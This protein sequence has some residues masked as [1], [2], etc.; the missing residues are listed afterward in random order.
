M[1]S[2]NRREFLKTTGVA[3]TLAGRDGRSVAIVSDPNDPIASS[4]PATWA[5]GELQRSLEKKGVLVRRRDSIQPGAVDE[6]LIVLSGPSV[7][8]DIPL[9]VVPEAFVLAPA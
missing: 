2:F 6:L 7:R 5:A 4:E 8:A 9:P 3:T 1:I